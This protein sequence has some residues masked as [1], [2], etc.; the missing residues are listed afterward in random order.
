M[1]TSSDSMHTQIYEK[2]VQKFEVLAD[3]GTLLKLKI[4][5]KQ[6][7]CTIKIINADTSKVYFSCYA[8]D[9]VRIPNE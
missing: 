6:P 3:I 1:V 4:K 9:E 7:P 8:S 2:E 5:D